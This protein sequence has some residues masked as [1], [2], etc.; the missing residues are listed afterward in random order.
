MLSLYVMGSKPEPECCRMTCRVCRRNLC[1]LFTGPRLLS[2]HLHDPWP[3]LSCVLL[4]AS[5]ARY[6]DAVALF[7]PLQIVW[8]DCA[9]CAA[10]P[11][12]RRWALGCASPCGVPRILFPR[13]PALG[14][15]TALKTQPQKADLVVV[16][17]APAMCLGQEESNESAHAAPS[18]VSRDCAVIAYCCLV[19]CSAMHALCTR[20]PPGALPPL[21]TAHV[22]TRTAYVERCARTLAH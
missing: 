6:D 22:G 7:A 1:V 5:L 9:A 10:P 20:L 16:P 8:I 3:A 14:P 21:L 15:R 13:F 11:V 4:C 2:T 19:V 18:P 12:C 17:R